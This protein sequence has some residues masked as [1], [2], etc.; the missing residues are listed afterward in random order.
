MPARVFA[1][2][3]MALVASLMVPRLGLTFSLSAASSAPLPKGVS[4]RAEIALA[5]SVADNCVLLSN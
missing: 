1:L 3:S 2:A 4:R 5:M